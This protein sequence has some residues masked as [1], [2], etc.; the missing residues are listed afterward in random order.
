MI[1]IKL[2]LEEE[3]MVKYL[4]DKYDMNIS[5]YLRKCIKKRYE[6]LKKQENDNK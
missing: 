4:R 3:N 1:G 2:D 5:A 6:E